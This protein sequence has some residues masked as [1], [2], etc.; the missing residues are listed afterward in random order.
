MKTEI[1]VY[2]NMK[3]TIDPEY[4]ELRMKIKKIWLIIF[5]LKNTTFRYYHHYA[6]FFI[7]THFRFFF[8]NILW[9]YYT[10]DSKGIMTHIYRISVCDWYD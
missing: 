6:S 8:P 7:C 1:K 10:S 2:K 5:I 9:L 4:I 3:I